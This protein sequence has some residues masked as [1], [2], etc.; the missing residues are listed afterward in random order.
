MI[1]AVEVLRLLG[2]DFQPHPDVN[3]RQFAILRK[4]VELVELD[5]E[6]NTI[7]WELGRTTNLRVNMGTGTLFN[8][9]S[10]GVV[11]IKVSLFQ[12]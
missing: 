11:Y 10:L 9:V 12:S 6:G 1:P 7:G 5:I 2:P 8:S 4:A 3:C